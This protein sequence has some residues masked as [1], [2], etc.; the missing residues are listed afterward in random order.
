MF[1]NTSIYFSCQA[2]PVTHTGT[3]NKVSA[4]NNKNGIKLYL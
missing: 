4:I 2:Y 1:A 3:L